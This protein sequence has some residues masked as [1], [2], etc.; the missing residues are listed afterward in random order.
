MDVSIRFTENS[1]ASRDF[2]VP[3]LLHL[4]GLCTDSEGSV[5]VSIPVSQT[6]FSVVFADDDTNFAFRRGH[7][8][9]RRA[10]PAE[11]RLP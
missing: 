4:T 2:T 3:E 6:K 7:V 5:T 10:S 9:G 1:L 8:L 11:P